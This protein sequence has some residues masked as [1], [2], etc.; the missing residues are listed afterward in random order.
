MNLDETKAMLLRHYR[1]PFREDVYEPETGPPLVPATITR[2]GHT[3]P[4]TI[5][6]TAVERGRLHV[7]SVAT[8]DVRRTLLD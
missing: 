2:H 7:F 8:S 6:A 1:A 4:A 5:V 3:V